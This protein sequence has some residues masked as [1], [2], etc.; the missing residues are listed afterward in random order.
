MMSVDRMLIE[1]GGLATMV[2]EITGTLPCASNR[3][4]NVRAGRRSRPPCRGRIEGQL[5]RAY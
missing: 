4:P 2:M 3:M 1:L 5:H